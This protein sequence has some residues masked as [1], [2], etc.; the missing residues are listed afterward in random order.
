MYLEV[1]KID[2]MKRKISKILEEYK[3]E[4][5]GLISIDIAG[6]FIKSIRGFFYFL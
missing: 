1:V 6:P 4:P 2:K 5:L 3:K